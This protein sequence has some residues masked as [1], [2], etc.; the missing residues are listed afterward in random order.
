M[1]PTPNLSRRDFVATSTALAASAALLR[2]A[3]AADEAAP[4]PAA[5]KF[6]PGK[7]KRLIV[8]NAKTGELETPLKLLAEHA[9]TPKELLFVRNNQI[10]PGALTLDAAKEDDWRI[11]FV[12]L[13][14]PTSITVAELKKVP[15]QE[16]ELVLQCSGNG[17]AW[18]ARS[19]KAEGAQWHN[20]AMGNVVFKGVPLQ[21]ALKHCKATL[22]AGARYLAAEGK[23]VPSKEG[24]DFEHSIPLDVALERSILALTLNGEP[25]PKV[26]GGPVRL[27]TPGYYGTMNVKWLS[28]LRFEA[29]ESKNHHHVGR[30][31][32]PLRPLKPG[33]EFKSTLANSEANWEMRIKSVIFSPLEG[34]RLSPGEVEIRG[35]AWNDGQTKIEA[36]EISADGGQSWRRAEITRPKSPY[37]WH[38][39]KLV[40]KL[41]AGKHKLLSRAIDVTGRA[42]PLD[43]AIGWNP[44]GYAWSGADVVNVEVTHG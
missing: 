33:S 17:R 36:V 3:S 34:A 28:K 10:M 20:G 30:Y 42:Q 15:Q 24:P 18:F 1:H 29:E 14:Q 21:A 2:G 41:T 12:G 6:I 9:I 26:H 27:V 23:D 31:R 40:T 19:V 16:H 25:I 35:V 39:W 32:T 37:A 43:G 38:P 7:D 11:E 8:H 5:D 22:A 44:A 4:L 13:D